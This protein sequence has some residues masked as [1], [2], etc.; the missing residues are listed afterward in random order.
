MKRL[1]I[2]VSTIVLI[3]S[4]SNSVMAASQW[5]FWGY[6]N[7]SMFWLDHSE[8]IVSPD[9]DTDLKMNLADDAQIGA[10]VKAS[11][12]VGGQFQ[13]GHDGA[14]GIYLRELYGTWNFGAGTLLVGQAWTPIDG[15]F[16]SSTPM[17]SNSVANVLW[18]ADDCLLPVGDT[19]D[20][21][22]P[23]I[24]LQF[25]NFKFAMMKPISSAVVPDSNVD[26]M[27]PKLEVRHLIK[28]DNLY[29]EP[30]AGY[31]YFK[32]D[33]GSDE[34]DI[35]A[36]VVGLGVGVDLGAASV[37][38]RIHYAQNSG[39]LGIATVRNSS[40]SA[41]YMGD[42]IVD[43]ETVGGLLVV[44]FKASDTLRLEFGTAYKTDELDTAGSEQD[45]VMSYYLQA[46]VNLAP[47]VNIVPEIG[48]VDYMDDETGHDE[49]K[50]TYMGTA[51]QVSF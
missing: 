1:L 47:G 20:Y 41:V 26:T 42:D 31:Q 24:Q 19:F 40:N 36:Y 38:A 8:E 21:R 7:M 30:F 17:P 9:G 2:L 37:K 39:N 49:G 28:I 29:V 13:I 4:F 14:N 34:Y 43:N 15:F 25:G 5:N 45:N 12:Y 16:S 11:D 50:T 27:L 51:L 32:N 46:A 18:E 35:N 3:G 48:V 33:T 10:A 6:A 22:Q 44:A 23:M